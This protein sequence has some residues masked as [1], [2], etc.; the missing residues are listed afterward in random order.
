[1]VRAQ[2]R[3]TAYCS[4]AHGNMKEHPAVVAAAL[5]ISRP[6]VKQVCSKGLIST[7]KGVTSP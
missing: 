7:V 3:D 2:A 4:I 5:L 6:F 1:M